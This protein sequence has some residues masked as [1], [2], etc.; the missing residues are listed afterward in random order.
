MGGQAAPNLRRPARRPALAIVIAAI[1]LLAVSR[2][3][4]IW[5]SWTTGDVMV[6]EWHYRATL[7]CCTGRCVCMP[8][9]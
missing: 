1:G 7:S 5:P 4:H 8:S 9:W 6:P 3:C 2:W